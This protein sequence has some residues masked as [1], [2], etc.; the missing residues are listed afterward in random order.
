MRSPLTLVP[1]VRRLSGGHLVE[2]EGYRVSRPR[3]TTDWLLVHTLGGRGRFGTD[4]SGDVL[5]GPAEVVLVAPGTPHDYGVE[6]HLQHWQIGFSHFHP[7]PE[8]Q[9]LLDW[10]QVAPGVGRLR[11]DTEVER[12]V[13]SAWDVV[14]FWSRSEQAHAE[15]FAMNALEQ[16]LLWC[17]TQNPRAVPLDARILRVLEHIDRHVAEPLTVAGLS[18]VAQL[19]TSRF[20]HLFTAQV[21]LPPAAYVERQRIAR[22]RLLLENTGCSV[23]DIARSVGFADPLYFSARFRHAVGVAPSHYRRGQQRSRLHG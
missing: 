9:F 6:P 17:D 10:P 1:E 22:A 8:W 2:T 7:R 12:R 4:D 20:A 23:A 11:L 14:F 3:G 18:G 5:V 15:L 19:S 16:V 13:R 21:G